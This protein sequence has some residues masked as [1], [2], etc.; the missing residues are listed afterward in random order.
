MRKDYQ[1][2]VVVPEPVEIQEIAVGCFDSFPLIINTFYPAQYTR[3]QGLQVSVELPEGW[4]G[5]GRFFYKGH[6]YERAKNKRQTS[7]KPKR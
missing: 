7:K 3:R 2:A 5:K 4:A 6:V 1:A